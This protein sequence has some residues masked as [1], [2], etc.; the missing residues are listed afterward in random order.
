MSSIIIGKSGNHNVSIDRKV[1]MTTRLLI[2]SDS[3][4]GK[5]WLLKRLIEQAFGQVGIIAID[6]EGEFAPLRTKFDFFLVGKGGDTPADVRT[7][8]KVARTLLMGRASAICDIYEMPASERHIWVQ[9]FLDALLDAP[10]ELRHP[11]FVIVD[12]AHMFCPEH[13]KGESVASEAMR[14]LATRGRKRMLCGIYATQRLATLSKDLSGM[15]LNRLIGPTF[16]SINQAAAARE[17]GIAKSQQREFF[18]SVKM[19]DPGYFYALGR[20]ITKDL[21]LVH[22]GPIETPHGQDALKY[23]LKPPPPTEKVR[24][25]L[26]KL[27]DLPKQAEEEARTAADFKKQIRGL[28]AQLHAQP[29]GAREIKIADPKAIDRAVALAARKY[30]PLKSLVEAAMKVLVKVTAIGFEDTALKPEQISQLLEATAREIAKLAKHNL[31]NRQIEF[32]RL[33]SETNRL[34]ASMKKLLENEDLKV[35]LTVSR[36]EPI[37][38][39]PPAPTRDQ[40]GT[41]DGD[42]EITRKHI[43]ILRALA[44]FAAIG[45]DTVPKKWIAARAGASHKSS[46][47][48]NNVSRLKTLGLIQYPGG[49][50]LK[51]TSEGT[52]RAPDFPRT[53]TSDEMLESCLKLLNRKQQLMLRALHEAY[54]RSIPKPELAERSESSATSS[55][56][57][58][59]ISAMRS[60]G[61]VDYIEGGIKAAEW[62]FLE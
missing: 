62:L 22:V 49:G 13:G 60:A 37:S 29:A 44:E 26:A 57:D 48:D 35:D 46:A 53:L 21:K 61:M 9:R 33:K 51:L 4:G 56:F 59:N 7:A 17:L 40:G 34:L 20:A 28:K 50:N 5:T 11:Y 47:F 14:G 42:G 30:A 52:A 55:A 39:R 58:N 27:G 1:L 36:N 38:V 41:S 24:E 31:A 10:K 3:G 16:E 45:K 8:E 18:A 15:C 32:D 6:P 43:D 25:W 19:L 2:T 12:E 23:E 54:P